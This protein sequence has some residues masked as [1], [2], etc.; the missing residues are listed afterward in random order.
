VAEHPDLTL[1]SVAVDMGG[2]EAARPFPQQAGATFTTVVDAENVLGRL[3]DFKIIPNGF[4]IDEQGIL[5]GKWLGF[6]VDNPECIAAV[7]RFREGTLEPFERTP[8]GAVGAPG[9]A[10][11]A[12]DGIGGLTA[13]EQEL[14]ATR[15]RFGTALKSLGREQEAITEWHKA[16]I[17]DPEN[18][19]LRKQIWML[20][21]PEKFHP[22][23]DFEWQK[24]QLAREKAEE[25]AMR[26]ANCG[27]EGC[28]IPAR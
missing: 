21:H 7:D 15:V 12:V 22:S 23:I 13:N 11:G 14:Y 9:V 8:Q 28:L 5:Q 24:E 27:P 20:R 16:L 26:L 17:M 18:F 19:V 10:P 25:D 6:S 4:F 1:L 3:F 2:A